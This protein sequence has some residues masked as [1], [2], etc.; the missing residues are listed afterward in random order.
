MTAAFLSSRH[1]FLVARTLLSHADVVQDGKIEEVVVLRYVSN[2]RG[3]VLK[4]ESSYVHT[5]EFYRTVL[6]I[7]KRSDKTC[8]C[9]FS[10]AGRTY[11]SVYR[12]G[13]DF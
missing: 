3:A 5:A 9:G 4:R 2:A 11:K 6:Y 8:D 13:L 7:P 12:A 10:A 1:N